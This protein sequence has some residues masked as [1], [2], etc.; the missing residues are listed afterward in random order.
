M[1]ILAWQ[2]AKW[3]ITSWV[4][5]DYDSSGLWVFLVVAGLFIWSLTS[6]RLVHANHSQAAWGI[7]VCTALIRLAGGVLAINTIGALA[8]A[9]DVLAL[10]LLA[11]LPQRRRALSPW[12]MT[13][14]FTL[15]LPMERILQ[16]VLGFGLQLLSAEG[17]GFMLSLFWDVQVQG[18]GIIL[19]GQNV[20]VDLPC[21]GARGIMQLLILLGALMAVVRPG[22]KRS[23]VA[24]FTVLL[25]AIAGNVCRI[26]LLALG[27]VFPAV[28]GGLDVM[29]QPWH[30]LIGL[31]CLALS[32]VPLLILASRWHAPQKP[33]ISTVGR[34]INLSPARSPLPITA[35]SAEYR[36]NL[37]VMAG[38]WFS[39]SPLP[40]SL[41][42]L[43]STFFIIN[44]PPRPLDVS[45]S[46]V[47]ATL[48]LPLWLDGHFQEPT[49]LSER[50]EIYFTRYGGEAAKGA[51]GSN[52]LMLV[53]TSSPLRHLHAPD[54]CLKGLG[55]EVDYLGLDRS[56]RPSAE[57]KAV[58]PDGRAWR[59]RVT[60]LSSS[61]LSATSVTEAVWH[62]LKS[63][64]T[65]T[66]V[67]RLTPWSANPASA[68]RWDNAVWA[69]LEN[70]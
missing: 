8:L 40:L 37:N 58:G 24:L 69:A 22:F 48:T 59:V 32:S 68:Q 52:G 19:S 29:A 46:E 38:G 67:Q 33:F 16:R 63:A 50:E 43:A 25:S 53:R 6:S 10:S 3:L 5:P 66:T 56:A 70:F 36:P 13:L 30:D 27:M 2:P 44:L 4:S 20:L 65:W 12:W 35:A 61:G 17:A 23:L 42:F 62:W 18:A 31:S 55:F 47:Y 49:P 51:Y 1:V 39:L 34:K 45:R 54:E 14:L 11:G 26:C 21:S 9:L 15:S 60:F 7:L 28:V 64:E 57:Y 41:L